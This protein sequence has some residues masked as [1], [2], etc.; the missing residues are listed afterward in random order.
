MY[1]GAPPDRKTYLLEWV[2]ETEK[3]L[4]VTA[5]DLGLPSN[6]DCTITSVEIYA[7]PSEW[8]TVLGFMAYDSAGSPTCASPALQL[9]EEET[10]R[11]ILIPNG[12]QVSGRVSS[13]S[14]VL[15]VTQSGF[16]AM[17]RVNVDVETRK[18]VYEIL[19][20]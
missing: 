12:P 20:G 3:C 4:T 15:R 14:P 8:P 17:I 11:W 10:T 9:T 16:T 19:Q 13:A 5:G 1:K 18:T 7:T 6:R 2:C